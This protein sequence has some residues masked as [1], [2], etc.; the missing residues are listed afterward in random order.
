MT[1]GKVTIYHNPRC[2]KSREALQIL[3]DNHISPQIIDYLDTAPDEN[4][5]RNIIKLLGISPRNLLRT[6]EAAYR[7]TGLDDESLSDDDV[8]RTICA[9]P[10]LLERPIIISGDKAVI[11]RPPTKILDII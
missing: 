6:G 11:G 1:D 5:L 4:E 10:V 2:S 3:K 8:I 9:H 7:E